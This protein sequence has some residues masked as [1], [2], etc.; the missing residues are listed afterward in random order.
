MFE[1]GF[2][3]TTYSKIN[4]LSVTCGYWID[5]D[6]PSPS[7]KM[8]LRVALPVIWLSATAKLHAI[9]K[10]VLM[11]LFSQVQGAWGPLKQVN[12]RG[13]CENVG[14]YTK[15]QLV[16]HVLLLVFWANNA[17]VVHPFVDARHLMPARSSG[18]PSWF[19]HCANSLGLRGP[20][21]PEEKSEQMQM[22][23]RQLHHTGHCIP[24]RICYRCFKMMH[25]LPITVK[26]DSISRGHL[27]GVS[28]S[29]SQR[30]RQGELDARRSFL[31]RSGRPAPS[32]MCS[33]MISVDPT[34]KHKWVGISYWPSNKSHG[35]SWSVNF[36]ECWQRCRPTMVF[37]CGFMRE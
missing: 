31:H 6:R 35:S 9:T 30:C 23:L 25:L 8:C 26:E 7:P 10:A 14:G 12:D 22:G 29:S 24:E 4:S 3:P 32:L 15:F 2:N 16:C 27:K 18:C 5:H 21:V 34:P 11:P 37:K 33:S 19:S 36:L 20:Q 13:C 1:W 17:G 28:L